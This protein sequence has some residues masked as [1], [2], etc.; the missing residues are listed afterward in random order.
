MYDVQI[1]SEDP[2]TRS[3]QAGKKA[4]MSKNRPQTPPRIQI[5][6]PL[7]TPYQEIRESVFRQAY[8][9]AGTQLRAAIALGITPDTVSR[10][11]R[12][13]DRAKG[14]RSIGLSAHRRR[15]SITRSTSIDRT[16]ESGHGAGGS[17]GH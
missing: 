16:V 8:Q 1:M 11:L 7:G 5:D 10:I 12:R 3:W 9:L 4:A 2:T 14:D 6:V 15:K 13:S 17:P